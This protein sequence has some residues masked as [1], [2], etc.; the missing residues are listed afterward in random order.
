MKEQTT[1]MSEVIVLLYEKMIENEDE[2]AYEKIGKMIESIEE[3]NEIKKLIEVTRMN[4][5]LAK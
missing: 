4:A 2:V 5:K 3:K 1:Q